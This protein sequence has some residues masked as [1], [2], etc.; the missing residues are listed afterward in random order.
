MTGRGLTTSIAWRLRRHQNGQR[1]SAAGGGLQSAKSGPVSFLATSGHLRSSTKCA[2]LP[3]AWDGCAEAHVE[4]QA[5]A[6]LID[7]LHLEGT[8]N[9]GIK[10]SIDPAQ[11]GGPSLDLSAP[12]IV[13]IAVGTTPS[14]QATGRGHL[15]ERFIAKLF[16]AYGCEAPSHSDLNITNNGYELDIATR[17]VL[18]KEAAIAECKAY[19]S[20][21]ENK[22]LSNFYGKLCTERFEIQEMHGWFVAIPGLT[23]AGHQLAR[24]LEQN[25]PKFRLITANTIYQLAI[26]KSWVKTIEVQ[27]TRVSDQAI[28]ITEAGLCSLAKELDAKTRL[29]NRVLVQRPSGQL[30]KQELDLLSNTAYVAGLEIRDIGA[31]SVM[32]QVPAQIEVSTLVS[33]VGSTNDFEYQFPAAPAFFVGRKTILADVATSLKAPNK[34]GR[35]IVLNAQSGWGKSSLA[36]K[37]ASLVTAASGHA[38]V[39]DSRTANSAQYVAAAL[40]DAVTNAA[41]KGILTIPSDASF[42]SLQS[43]IRTFRKSTW[44]SRSRPLLIFFDQFENVFRDERLTEEFRNLSLMIREVDAPVI[45]GFCWKTDQVALTENYPY[46]LRDEIRGTATVINVEPFGPND[47]GTVLNRLAKAAG[48]PISQ[49]LRQRI[50]EYS[51]GL[52]WLLKKLASHI[53]KEL[54]AGTSEETLLEDSLNIEG[55]FAQ[56]LSNLQ[57]AEMDALRLI[58]REAPVPFA[59]IVERVESDVIQSLV[60]QRL[61]VKVGE[62]LDTYWDIFREFLVTGKVAV[63]DTYILRQRPSSTSKFLKAVIEAGGEISASDVAAKFGTSVNVVFNGA[64]E[65]RQLN[66]LSPKSGSLALVE[67]LRGQPI[68]EAQLQARVAKALRRHRVF[69]EVQELQSAATAAKISIDSLAAQLPMIYPAVKAGKN[70]WRIYAMAFAL[71]LEYGGLISLRGQEIEAPSPMPSTAKLL[72]NEGRKNRQRTFP[73]AYPAAA[74]DYLRSKV[75]P[76]ACVTLTA[77][78]ASKAVT[79]LQFLGLLDVDGEVIDGA[80]V[81][82]LVEPSTM[83]STLLPLLERVPGGSDA[84]DLL[85]KMPLATKDHVGE[86]LRD[87]YGLP[88]ARLTIAKAGGA[89]RTWAKIAGIKLSKV[90]MN[91]SKPAAR[92]FAP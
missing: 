65:L 71:W 79:D 90:P 4:A 50:R 47:V 58:A 73:Q 24:R 91:K 20:P 41:K 37:I 60:D 81:R 3:L 77:S 46:R 11:A 57:P 61:L 87:A 16:E 62:R 40:Q 42:A 45:I 44:H 10:V 63:E 15:F 29:P 2:Q 23:S 89:F 32:P 55:L 19:T 22:M 49:D 26:D 83:A 72:G 35:V 88:W 52:P 31:A 36:L 59:D 12:Q 17:F 28:L 76:T 21:V 67:Q 82:A 27:H 48:N 8:T 64:R 74:F 53:L 7:A 9:Q 43:A 80:L 86:V 39:F 68:A 5:G 6:N 56:D 84:I 30:T 92:G 38:M 1:R 51:Q 85:R 33:V 69:K 13:L 78:S 34:S 66:I 70:T 25:D 14:A 75:D 54:R 18:S